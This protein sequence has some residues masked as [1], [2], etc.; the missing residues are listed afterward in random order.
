M[1]HVLARERRFE[2]HLEP[3]HAALGLRSLQL[4]QLAHG[5]LE[6]GRERPLAAGRHGR[7]PKMVT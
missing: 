5:R 7:V 1:E 4:N 6:K 2:Y 3:A